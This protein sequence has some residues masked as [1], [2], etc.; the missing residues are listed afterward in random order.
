MGDMNCSWAS[1]I[2]GAQ[3]YS[4]W[5]CNKISV[6]VTAWSVRDLPTTSLICAPQ[7]GDAL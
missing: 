1:M 7:G 5:Y 4:K 2:G 6:H 3:L